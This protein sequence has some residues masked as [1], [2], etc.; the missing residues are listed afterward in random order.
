[1]LY[2]QVLFATAGRKS[3][4]Q[5]E[6]DPAE[7]YLNRIDHTAQQALKEMRLLVY[8]LN[9]QDLLVDGLIS[10]LNHRLEAVEQRAGMDVSLSVE[11]ELKL[12][13]Y[14]ELELYRLV[15]E[16]LNN[17]LKH[18]QASSVNI[19]I[20][21]QPQNLL[22]EIEDDGIGF[23]LQKESLSG[24][25]GLATMEERA[26]ALSGKL[27]ISTEPNRGTRIRTIIEDLQ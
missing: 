27:I 26:A 18:A 12:D 3:I 5:G 8:E 7:Q 4:D 23:D 9:P 1:M 14:L 16:A 24:G 22:I 20:Q 21:S 10:A 2:S 11:G 15:Q 25:M 13:D 6:V 17:T 19:R